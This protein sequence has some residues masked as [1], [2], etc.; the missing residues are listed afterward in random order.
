M[1]REQ[2]VVE[3]TDLHYDYHGTEALTGVS[4]SLRAGE[5]VGLIGPN[6]AGKSTLLLHLNGLLAGRGQVRVD[7]TLLGAGTLAE[8]RAKI[9]LV[10]SDPEDQ[11]FMPTLL[12]DAAFGPLNMGLDQPTAL[13]RAEAALT[14]L[15]LA[16]KLDRSPHHLSDGE[17][18]RAALAT[19]LS[20]EPAVWVLDEPAANLDPR[21]RRELITLLGE[22]TG[23]VLL[24]SHDLDMVVQTCQRCLLLDGGKLVRDGDTREVLSDVEL[25]QTHGLEV[26][27]RLELQAC[28][29]QAVGRS[30]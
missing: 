30:S 12:E 23:T 5:R 2:T 15:G 26:P 27:L 28:Q 18:R 14:R 4:F 13:A 25:M 21:G 17:R 3:V 22:L 6:G 10:F 8:V 9:G 24:A 16:D 19:V 7:G 11:L 29:E 1:T 20:M